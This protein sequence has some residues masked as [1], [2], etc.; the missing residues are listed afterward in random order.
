MAGRMWLLSSIQRFFNIISILIRQTIFRHR[1]ATF[2][3]WEDETPTCRRW[4]SGCPTITWLESLRIL[5]PPVISIRWW[6][7]RIR[8]WRITL[9]ERWDFL[10]WMKNAYFDEFRSNSGTRGCEDAFCLLTSTRI[11][12]IR[13]HVSLTRMSSLFLRV[14][15]FIC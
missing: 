3:T 4:I 6:T 1:K 12:R 10:V 11:S 13:F 7:D 2:C 5:N 14:N 15:L 9:A 8:Y